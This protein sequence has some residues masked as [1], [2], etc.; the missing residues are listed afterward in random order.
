M[1]WDLYP[2]IYTDEFYLAL[3]QFV[4]EFSE[5]EQAMQVALWHLVKVKSPVAQAVFS[6]VR[7]DDAA[8]K[9][10]RI[11]AAEKWPK[12]RIDE[13]SAISGQLGVIR[14]FRNDILHYGVKWERENEWVATNRQFV[15]SPDR[16]TN[17]PVTVPILEAAI[18]DLK[19]LGLHIFYFCFEPTNR[20]LSAYD[21]T[22]LNAWQYKSSP[23]ASDPNK[24]PGSAPKQ[25]RQ[26]KPS[27]AARRKAAQDR[28]SREK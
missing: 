11:G 5:I 3:G 21:R 9:I 7:A 18:E 27:A 8:N 4:S 16:I 12:A 20:S 19:S 25:K 6:G 26:Q 22:Q 24:T 14:S 1:P 2:R 10:A 17:A 23:P 15:H 13:W 28:S